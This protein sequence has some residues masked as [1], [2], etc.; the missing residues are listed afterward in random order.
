ML[1]LID[2]SGYRSQIKL[3]PPVPTRSYCRDISQEFLNIYGTV[4]LLMLISIS[5]GIR[6]ICMHKGLLDLLC[7]SNATVLY[8][9]QIRIPT[10]KINYGDFGSCYIQ[11]LIRFFNVMSRLL[12]RFWTCSEQDW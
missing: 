9:M 8:E 7:T 2:I 6:Q 10:T 4:E 12:L 5:H 11:M 3:P 1:I